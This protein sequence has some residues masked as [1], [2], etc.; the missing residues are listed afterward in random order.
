MPKH[1]N[2]TLIFCSFFLLFAKKSTAQCTLAYNNSNQPTINIVTNSNCE[3]E[4]N[5][6]PYV[7]TT[8]KCPLQYFKDAAMTMPYVGLP[9]FNAS[10]LG[11]TITIFVA[12]TG[13][14]PLA[15]QVKIIDS[16][17]PSMFCPSSATFVADGVSCVK[18]INSGLAA[19]AIDN[20]GGGVTMTWEL[21][22]ATMGSGS[23]SPNGQIFTVGQTIIKY[24]GTDLAGNTG[25][26][27]ATVT[28][29]EKIAPTLV[30]CPPSITL[31]A[32]T[33]T[34]NRMIITGLSASFTDNCAANPN[35]TFLINGVTLAA[36]QGSA[37][38]TIFNVGT[39]LI[40]YFATDNF[41]NTNNACSFTVTIRDTDKPVIVCPTDLTINT[42]QDSCFTY[43]SSTSL[44]PVRFDNCGQNNITTTF[45]ISGATTSATLP[46]AQI[47]NQRF[48]KGQNTVTFTATDAS[49]N[50][51]T[52]AMSVLIQDKTKPTLT[53]GGG[54]ILE[55]TSLGLC[56]KVLTLPQA[57]YSDNCTPTNQIILTY[58]ITGTTN[59]NGTGAI[60]A[61]QAFKT[62][63]SIV[64]YTAT[65][66]DGNSAI[67]SYEIFLKE[68][69]AVRPDIVCRQDTFVLAENG[70]C[71]RLISNGLQPKTATDNCSTQ[72]AMTLTA[73]MS[74]ASVL[75]DTLLSIS[76]GVNG[77]TFNGGLTTVRYIL[78]DASGNADTC[79]FSVNVLDQQ[80]PVIQ[81]VADMT[82]S[83]GANCQRKISGLQPTATDNCST[84]NL[85]FT[86]LLSG[87]TPN[88]VNTQLV[89]S[90]QFKVGVT[91][92][93]FFV[94]DAANNR[95][96]CQFKV[97]VTETTVPTITCPN[98]LTINT[99]DTTCTAFL[100]NIPNPVLLTIVL[101]TPI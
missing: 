66:S 84:A 31:D 82:V 32:P 81:C 86:Y 96:T 79:T 3:A 101:Q 67:C 77:F 62:G 47:A 29:T 51:N 19:T 24:T 35:T 11:Q 60:P 95:D 44:T 25:T 57:T 68:T 63:K 8:G 13:V 76:Q 94:R 45:K 70:K 59:A 36:G 21:T 4:F 99:L 64:T 90:V 87:A 61:T 22:G 40:R 83:A 98:N 78:K 89:D 9:M 5:A 10:N 50:S 37:N 97:T 88:P 27:N 53:C 69:P 7:N 1:L 52:C 38:S 41:S 72:D 20:C 26:C 85:Q 6:S 33:G 12:V 93:Q 30:S 92:V 2:F 39:S 23:N 15:F 75:A 42:L 14:S 55:N 56:E 65:D 48:F 91:T 17:A 34:C 28:L 74:G 54:N 18:T 58:K 71:T 43:I 49:G 46:L 80:K 100:Q 16:V 73:R